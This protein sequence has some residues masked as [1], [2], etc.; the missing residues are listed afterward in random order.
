MRHIFQYGTPIGFLSII[1]QI[2]V[3]I[4]SLFFWYASE[5]SE[6]HSELVTGNLLG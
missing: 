2:R 4:H 1:M 5:P 6:I 3:V